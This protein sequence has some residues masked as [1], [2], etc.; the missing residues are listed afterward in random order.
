MTAS[1]PCTR[2][3]A[4]AISQ[5]E[6]NEDTPLL[7]TRTH[8]VNAAAHLPKPSTD[9]RDNEDSAGDTG[10]TGDTGEDRPLPM[11]QIIFL[12]TARLIE[13]I[14]FFSI[15]PY[16]NKM[17]K[18]NGSLD[19]ADVGFYSGLI[20]S[21]FSLTQ[22]LVM[23]FWGRAADRLGRKPILVFSMAGVTVATSMFGMATTIREMIL[24][25]CLAGVFAGTIL[26][27]RTMI[28]EHSTIKTQARA[29]SLFAFTGNLG[30]L[31]GPLIGGMLAEPSLQYPRFFSGVPFFEKYPY[32][33]P[34]FAVGALGLVITL[35]CAVNI[36]E[37]LPS[38]IAK[39]DD[40]E[41]TASRSS[42]ATKATMST[43]KLIKAP[44]VGLVLYT[45][46]HISL[47]AFA[48][49]AVVPVFWY[50]PVALGGLGF[51]PVKISAFMGLNGLSQAAWLLLIFPSLHR[52]I[53]TNGVLRVCATAYPVFLAIP[54]LLNLLLRKGFLTIFWI[55]APV[56]MALGCGVAM[57]F[58][59]IQLAL[60]DVAPSPQILGTLNGICLAMASGVRSFSPALFASLFAINARTQWLWGYA[61]WL[62][63]IIIAFIFTFLSGRM[64]DYDKLRKRRELEATLVETA[65]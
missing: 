55:S 16:I 47:L 6:I 61:I 20:E 59:A 49:T 50:T 65:E 2:G 12:C 40:S 45:F 36:E 62:L 37:T 30:I 27:I 11:K 17:C 10:D 3:M 41:E 52:R 4:P 60:N 57:S 23:V 58:T 35:I 63:L 9:T 18:E 64:P 8:A 33:L 32:A 44:G 15:F 14:A 1:I 48:Y 25:R 24:F 53:G 21:L 42:T 54:P 39:Q 51:S 7:T 31:F 43:W 13:P 34:S 28:S 5:D 29:F 56:L 26:T 38:K 22:M 46:Q 19:E